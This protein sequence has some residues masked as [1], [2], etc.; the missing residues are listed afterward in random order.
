[1]C[2]SVLGSPLPEDAKAK[3]IENGETNTRK[4]LDTIEKVYLEDSEFLV[5]NQPTV[6][7]YFAAEFMCVLELKAY[8]FSP[9]PKVLNF[10][11]GYFSM[12]GKVLVV[13]GSGVVSTCETSD[14]LG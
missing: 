11:G 1:M 5:G 14:W 9:W 13:P 2:P 4:H 10:G 6:A 7:D 12:V 8:D 3:V